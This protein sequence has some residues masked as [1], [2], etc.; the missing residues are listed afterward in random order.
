MIH[1][2]YSRSFTFVLEGVVVSIESPFFAEPCNRG[3]YA[4]RLDDTCVEF[5]SRSSSVWPFWHW[6]LL[7]LHES[8][9]PSRCDL[10]RISCNCARRPPVRCTRTEGS[11]PEHGR[12]TWK[13]YKGRVC[14]G[15]CKLLRGEHPS[16]SFLRRRKKKNICLLLNMSS[17]TKQQSSTESSTSSSWSLNNKFII[18]AATTT[19]VLGAV[20]YVHHKWWKPYFNDED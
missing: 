4:L 16:R 12:C 3:R 1:E 20:Y 11:L 7:G 18:T 10:G 13:R 17:A 8:P 14:P 2:R 5:R 19:L 9:L 6:R 15:S